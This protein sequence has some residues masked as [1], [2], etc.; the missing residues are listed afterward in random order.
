[1]AKY[2]HLKAGIVKPLDARGAVDFEG[3]ARNKREDV[4]KDVSQG[5]VS[6]PAG[7]DPAGLLMY[8]A[9]TGNVKDGKAKLVFVSTVQTGATSVEE[10][11]KGFFGAL[12]NSA[13]SHKPHFESLRR[14]F[15][16]TTI[17]TF[18][19]KG[20]GGKKPREH[21]KSWHS[22]LMD[23]PTEKA[24]SSRSMEAKR[25]SQ[26]IGMVVNDQTWPVIELS[27][28]AMYPDWSC[29]R[30]EFE[31]VKAGGDPWSVALNSDET[32]E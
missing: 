6:L 16:E 30:E 32:E 20:A 5:S 9:T 26:F 11:L 31:I 2:N 3:Y 19:K 7:F 8:G 25:L 24:G 22:L 13:E 1:M 12:L 28:N 10:T 21:Y 14:Y 18:L 15:L 23:L 29:S 27:L 4:K 17:P